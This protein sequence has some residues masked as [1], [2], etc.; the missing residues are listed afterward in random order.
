MPKAATQ[1][2]PEVAVRQY[3]T[4]LED[5]RKLVDAGEVK[6]LES[7]VTAAKDP[8]ER[9]RAIAAL[10]RAKAAD[11]ATYRANFIKHAKAWS[12]SE[13]IPEDAFRELG[14]PADVLRAAGFG[15]TRGGRGG[16]RRARTES[17]RRPRSNINELSN[18][19]LAL[20]GAFS[21]KDVM[22]RVGGSPATVKNVVLNLESQGKLADA[23]ERA[24]ARGRA[25]RVWRVV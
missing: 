16:G 18:G 3:L 4:Y 25:A 10:Q 12:S 9:V 6:K 21:I 5:P 11:E 15:A 19:V 2:S 7:K 22:E 20:S 24:G 8:V 17:G 23:G 13:G 1:L 14:V